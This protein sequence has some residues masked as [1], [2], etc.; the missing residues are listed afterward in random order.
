VVGVDPVEWSTTGRTKD[1]LSPRAPLA[2]LLDWL[3]VTAATRPEPR[4][5]FGELCERLC[6]LGLPLWRS[7]VQLEGLHPL[8]YGYCLHWTRGQPAFELLRSHAFAASEEFRL[9]PY[10]ASLRAGGSYRSRLEA[11]PA[12]ELPLLAR[13]KAEGYTDFLA[14]IIRT[15]DPMLPGVTWATKRP[16]GFTAAEVEALRAL[17]PHLGPALG[18]GAERQKIDAVLRTYLGAGPAREVAAGHVRRGDLRRIEAVVL[19][20]DLRGFSDKLIAWPEGELIEALGGYFEAVA[21]AVAAHGG[22][23][24]KLIGDGVLAVFPLQGGATREEVCVGALV[25]AGQARDAVADLNGR[26]TRL[27]QPPLDFVAV[28]HLG[29]L[30]YG[31]VG[32]RERLDFTVL[33]PAVNVTSRLEALAK[34]IG[35]KTLLT[36]EVAAHAPRPTRRLGSFALRGLPGEWVVHAV[37]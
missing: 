14:E 30:A 21:D 31:N 35:E 19:L 13:L 15:P 34:R 23:V 27:G 17:A 10:M 33:G 1:V 37:D 16:A 5:L 20:T 32:A 6:G 18:W 22:D 36:A 26:R 3:V 29:P 4:H 12:P 28:L 8:Y 2:G 11:D 7:A 25:A 9:S 24:L